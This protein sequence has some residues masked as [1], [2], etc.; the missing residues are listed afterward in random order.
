VVLA[1]CAAGA[2]PLSSARAGV[3]DAREPQDDGWVVVGGGADDRDREV[4]D[5]AVVAVAREVGWS[6]PREPVAQQ[7]TDRLLA[8]SDPDRP[9]ACVPPAVVRRGVRRI[10]VFAL[11]HQHADSGAPIVV[12]T[13]RLIAAAPPALVVRQRFCEHCADDRL[14]DAAAELARQLLRDLA[15]RSGRTILDVASSPSGAQITLDGRPVGATNATF[16]TF[17]GSHV[18]VVDKAG[19]RSELRTVVASEGK[20][21]Q[22]AVTLAAADPDEPADRPSRL[23]PRLLVG[24]GILAAIA[25]GVL[26]EL[27]ARG[28]AQDRYRYA[29]AT[30]AGAA[31]GVAGAAA[32]AAGIYVW[33]HVPGSAAPAA[34]AAPSS[35]SSGGVVAGLG[36]RF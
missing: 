11:D 35:G 12:I 14:A 36:G 29:G 13:A 25:G 24:G 28:G 27:G 34:P 15:V 2:A 8:C 18:V 33:W 23:V 7:D 6:L 9:F 20:T 31:I 22:V 26:L 3:R 30:P 19:F 1:I 32:C 10:L 16:N 21:A 17:P 4:V 5:A